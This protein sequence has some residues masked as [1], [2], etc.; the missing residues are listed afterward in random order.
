MLFSAT[1]MAMVSPTVPEVEQKAEGET[2]VIRLL[3]V[4]EENLTT[5][6]QRFKSVSP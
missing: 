1:E 6:Y 2:N 5:F 4:L 3:K